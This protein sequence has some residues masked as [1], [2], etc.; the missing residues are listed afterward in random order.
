MTLGKWYTAH[1]ASLM[2]PYERRG[3]SAVWV[4]YKNNMG[5]W[6]KTVTTNTDEN[7]TEAPENLYPFFEAIFK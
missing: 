6:G 4:V 1:Y 3:P 5:K 7:E 2:F